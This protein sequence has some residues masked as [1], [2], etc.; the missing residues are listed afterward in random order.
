M[1]PVGTKVTL[2]TNSIDGEMDIKGTIAGLPYQDGYHNKNGSWSIY[3]GKGWFP[4]YKIA[5][6]EYRQKRKVSL[7]SIHRIVK[8]REGWN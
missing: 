2:T 8:W 5:F 6:R 4:C 1:P 3:G 7:V